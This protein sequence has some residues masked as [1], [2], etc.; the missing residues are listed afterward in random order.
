MEPG[1]HARETT[2]PRKEGLPSIKKRGRLREPVS[3]AAG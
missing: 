3:F 2:I 1:S